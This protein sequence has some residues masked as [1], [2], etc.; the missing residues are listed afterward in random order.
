[1]VEWI[2]SRFPLER[3]SGP[4][5]KHPLCPVVGEM[6]MLYEDGGRGLREVVLSKSGLLYGNQGKG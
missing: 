1:M 5:A 6:K 3:E 4:L 2:D